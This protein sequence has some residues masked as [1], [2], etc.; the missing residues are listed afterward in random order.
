MTKTQNYRVPRII[1]KSEQ[2]IKT[3]HFTLHYEGNWRIV[4]VSDNNNNNNVAIRTASLL[5]LNS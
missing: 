1:T 2:N 5:L 4:V 3:L